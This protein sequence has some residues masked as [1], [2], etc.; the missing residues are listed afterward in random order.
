MS[1]PPS[2]DPVVA[3]AWGRAETTKKGPKPSLQLPD[4]VAAAV[5]IADAEG[6]AA[7]S[8]SRVAKTLG[9]TTMSVYRYV[10]SKD[11]LLIHMQDAAMGIPDRTHSVDVGWRAGLEAWAVSLLKQL[12]QHRWYVDIPVS[13]A[14]LMPNAVA[15]M[16]RA[17]LFLNRTSLVPMERLSA[18]LL[19]SG[20]VRNEV[21]Q[22]LSLERGRPQS[23]RENI[24]EPEAEDTVYADS[25]R[26]LIDP[27]SHPGVTQLLEEGMFSSAEEPDIED[28]DTFMLDFGLQRILDGLEHL[29][30]LRA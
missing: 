21:S 16:D 7:V 30:S 5:E 27:K 11:E 1:L 2:F 9:F 24:H 28:G 13:A 6:L 18:L 19:M 17:M 15:W 14:P 8:M 22:Q 4:V 12:Q 23:W 25:L 10:D 29:I 26:Q 20:Y 3:A